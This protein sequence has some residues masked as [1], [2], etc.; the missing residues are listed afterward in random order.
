M[1]RGQRPSAYP[2]WQG[3]IREE[4][5]QR[6][7]GPD[8]KLFAAV[9]RNAYGIAGVLNAANVLFAD[10]DFS[11]NSVGRAIQACLT[12]STPSPPPSAQAPH[13]IRLENALAHWADFLASR[14]D[15]SSRVY[16]TCAGLRI[17]VTHALFDPADNATMQLL[18]E[19]GCDSLYV[20]LC[21]AQESFRARLTPKPW[22]CGLQQ[23]TVRWPYET[24]EQQ[25]RFEEG[26]A[27]YEKRQQQFATC[28][29]FSTVGTLLGV[30]PSIRAAHRRLARR[31]HSRHGTT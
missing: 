20:R 23:N 31:G 13:A 19:A 15:W 18:N 4:V 3:A 8:G 30:C 12:C 10:V 7:T 27:E 22:R 5:L 9:T 16:R 21:K 1:F 11:S 17:L 14:R 28:R 6:H 25:R 2:Y 26:L 29:F 24:D